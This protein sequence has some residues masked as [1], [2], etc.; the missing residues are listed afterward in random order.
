MTAPSMSSNGTISSDHHHQQA[1]AQPVHQST[2]TASS[3]NA[4]DIASESA[5]EEKRVDMSKVYALAD[6]KNPNHKGKIFAC[7]V[8]G[9]GKEALA[10]VEVQ[11]R[12][13][14][15]CS[16]DLVTCIC[17]R[18]THSSRHI[19]DM[20]ANRCFYM[21]TMCNVAHKLCTII[22]DLYGIQKSTNVGNLV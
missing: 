18:V 13:D 6:P 5:R 16:A 11:R 22:G 10:S 8:S 1:A 12:K 14:A 15:E 20:S 19:N 21:Q 3:V 9:L 17:E 2:E 7:D 4:P